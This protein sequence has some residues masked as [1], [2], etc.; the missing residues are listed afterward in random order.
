MNRRG[1][2]GGPSSRPRRRVLGAVLTV[3]ALMAGLGGCGLLGGSSGDDKP[4][5]DGQNMKIRL[6]L[7]KVV[8]VAPV[9]IAQQAGFFKAEGLDLELIPL[10]TS[11]VGIDKMAAGEMDMVHGNYVSMFTA[12]AKKVV[13]LKWVADCY[14]AK[15]NVWMTMTSPTSSVKSMSDLPGKKVAVTT[16]SNLADMTVWSVLSAHNVDAKQIKY[17]QMPFTEMAAALKN[18][19]VDA[20]VMAEPFITQAAKSMGAVRVF[21]AASGPTES[22]PMA[23][24]STN[25]KFAAANPKALAAFQRGLAKGVEIANSD[26][27]RVEAAVQGY[28]GIDAQT[29]SIMNIGAYPASLEAARLQRVPDLMKDFGILSERIDVSTMVLPQAPVPAK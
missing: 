20:A 14:A 2:P 13:D 17:V 21:D 15:P 25:A 3:T 22:I 18:G 12:H 24:Y 23:G 7:V 6:G 28:A 29:A 5:G 8:D 4:S 19:N 26:R 16:T 10:T 27:A 9:Y 1:I 11:A